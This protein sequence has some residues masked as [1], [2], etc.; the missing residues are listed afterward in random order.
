MKY[1]IKE[2]LYYF[3]HRVLWIMLRVPST[4][5]RRYILILCG[6]KISRKVSVL[7]GIMVLAPWKLIIGSGTTVN[8]NVLLDARGGI[9]IGKNVQIGYGS[10]I[11]SMG[12]S[13]KEPAFKAEKKRVLIGDNCVLFS[14]VYIGPGTLIS[15]NVI[16]YPRCVVLGNCE[17][18][19]AS[20]ILGNPYTLI[21]PNK[22]KLSG[23]KFNPSPLGL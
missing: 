4:T 8:S 22:V 6:A 17:I 20:R 7:S 5:F 13:I 23:S 14:E 2:N 12:H 1:V 16:A 9:Q 18:K 15:D 3:L 11:H 21:S 10:K 19:A